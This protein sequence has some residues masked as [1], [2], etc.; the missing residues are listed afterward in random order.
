MV[1]KRDGRLSRG[2]YWYT[3]LQLEVVWRGREMRGSGGGTLAGTFPAIA[4]I[5]VAHVRE[6][7]GRLR[8]ASAVGSGS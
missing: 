7:K 1:R 8:I 3:R 5:E 6:G 2:A 4:I